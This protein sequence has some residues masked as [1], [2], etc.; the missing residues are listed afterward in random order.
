MWQGQESRFGLVYKIEKVRLRLSI[1]GK[2]IPIDLF[3]NLDLN[4]N[5]VLGEKYGKY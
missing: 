2:L 4:L 5:L 3:P 1:T